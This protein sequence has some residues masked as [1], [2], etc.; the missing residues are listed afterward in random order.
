M[1]TAKVDTNLKWVRGDSLDIP[2]ALLDDGAPVDISGQTILLTIKRSKKDSD[3][4]AL[5]AKAFDF[6]ETD[7][8]AQIG[9][10]A[11][12]LSSID[13]DLPVGVHFYDFQLTDTR[14]SPPKV[15][16]LQAGQITIREDVTRRTSA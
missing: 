3:D 7:E 16:T 14:V 1:A 13:T 4:H 12:N 2:F 11:I 8:N 15:K 5:L 6:P 10:G 9:Q